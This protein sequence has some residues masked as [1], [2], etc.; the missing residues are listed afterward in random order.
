MSVLAGGWSVRGLDLARLPGFVIAVNDAGVLAPKVDAVVTMDRLWLE[1]R[2]DRLCELQRQTWVRPVCLNNIKDRPAW[3]NIYQCDWRETRLSGAKG[4]LNGTN[5]G[6]VALNLAYQ[7]RPARVILFGFDM[8]RSPMGEAYWYPPY[9]YRPGGATSN[10]KYAEWA[11]QFKPAAEA[12]ERIGAEVLN[13]SPAS[14]IPA[15]KKV[16]PRAVL[17]EGPC[18]TSTA[19]SRA[20]SPSP[21]STATP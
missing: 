16:D 19:P 2:W 14:R 8:G 7:M 10:G 11:G 9:A 6:L 17:T 13:A 1:H 21:A 4:I 15:F 3:L 20:G 18:S 5:S 12:F